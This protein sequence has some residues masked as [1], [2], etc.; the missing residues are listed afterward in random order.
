V[1]KAEIG[2]VSLSLFLPLY[3]NQADEESKK[4][5]ARTIPQA[6]VVAGVSSRFEKRNRMIRF[7]FYFLF[8][9][10]LTHIH[11]YKKVFLC[12]TNEIEHS[13]LIRK[14]KCTRKKNNIFYLLLK[15]VLT[16]FQELKYK[17]V[18]TNLNTEVQKSLR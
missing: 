4:E 6:T 2:S 14:T 3:S 9:L 10:P 16:Y 11:I 18:I 5:N 17:V 13:N 7:S 15:H 1:R 12:P 8:F